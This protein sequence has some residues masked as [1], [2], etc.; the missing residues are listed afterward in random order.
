M[1]LWI[2]LLKLCKTV[3]LEYSIYISEL[4]NL[5]IVLYDLDLM[6][7]IKDKILSTRCEFPYVNCYAWL[8]S[9]HSISQM[10]LRSH[11]REGVSL[12]WLFWIS[13]SICFRFRVFI[14]LWISWCLTASV[15]SDAFEP[16]GVGLVSQIPVLNTGR[17]ATNILD[18]LENK[19]KEN[20]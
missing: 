4:Y 7:K 16:C 9:P 8:S 19:L 2:I 6:L 5:F 20:K 12:P 13:N 18:R 17:P 3:E 14:S 1:V 11:F 15:D 10:H